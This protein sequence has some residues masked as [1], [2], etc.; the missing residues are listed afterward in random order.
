MKRPDHSCRL[1]PP[2]SLGDTGH[3]GEGLAQRTERRLEGVVVVLRD[4]LR[5]QRRCLDAPLDIEQTCVAQIEQPPIRRVRSRDPLS[6][7]PTRPD[8]RRRPHRPQPP[9]RRPRRG[10]PDD[11]RPSRSPDRGKVRADRTRPVS[12]GR[13]IPDMSSRTRKVALWLVVGS[14]VSA[15]GLLLAAGLGSPGS[16]PLNPFAPGVISSTPSPD[17]ERRVPTE[18]ESASA[19]DFAERLVGL[20]ISEPLDVIVDPPIPTVAN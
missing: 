19:I 3:R 13:Y 7:Q 20:P 6:N 5:G 12:T 10:T 2:R 14:W 18:Q 16:A 9:H 8:F 17:P 4:S 1:L 11:P 15:G